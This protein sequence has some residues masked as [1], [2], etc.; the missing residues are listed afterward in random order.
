V[1]FSY[2][3]LLQLSRHHQA[4]VVLVAS[5]F[6]VIRCSLPFPKVI[7]HSNIVKQIYI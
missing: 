6:F 2:V 7:G 4:Y 5:V 3:P 1:N